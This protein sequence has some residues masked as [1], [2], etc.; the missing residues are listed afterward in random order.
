M[1]RNKKPRHKKTQA[2]QS[3][4]NRADS[5]LLHVSET[6]EFSGPIPPPEVLEKYDRIHSGAANRIIVMAENEANHRHDMEQLIVKNQ[7]R[8]ARIGQFCALAIGIAA[9][10]AGAVTA[11]MGSAISGAIIGGGGVIGL[12]SVFVLGRAGKPIN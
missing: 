11:I 2:V 8:E 3:P 10:I 1:S 6:R 7:Y 4:Q 5:H 12:V 9:I